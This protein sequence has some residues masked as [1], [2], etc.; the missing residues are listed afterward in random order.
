VADIDQ[1]A[2]LAEAQDKARRAESELLELAA[3]FDEP[4]ARSEYPLTLLLLGHRSRTLFRAFLHLQTGSVPVAARALIRPMVEINILIRFLRQDPDLHTELWQAEGDRSSVTMSEDVRLSSHL[5]ARLGEVPL[6]EVEIEAR[7]Q[8]VA[9][10]R[11][12]AKD[13]GLPVSK[14]GSVLPSIPGQ[15][16]VIEEPAA[17]SAYVF[18]Y[19]SFSWEVHAGPRAFLVGTLTSTNDGRVFYDEQQ[20]PA[21]LLHI[22]VVAIATFASTVELVGAEL[23]L[24]IEAPAREIRRL[25]VPDAET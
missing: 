11:E 14:N 16:K 19:R 6:D 9:Q 25:F 24:P 17:D 15:L 7:Q 1:D 12:R 5:L 2:P 10:A 23:G 21:D 20:S 18:L 22:H 13:A 8:V 4:V 3:A